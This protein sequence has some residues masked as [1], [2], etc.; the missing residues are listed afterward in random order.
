LNQLSKYV[1]S[2]KGPAKTDQKEKQLIG[3]KHEIKITNREEVMVTDSAT[4]EEV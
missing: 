1:S 4:E 2:R 3:L